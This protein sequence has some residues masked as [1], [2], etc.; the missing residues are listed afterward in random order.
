MIH[1]NK[2]VMKS[3]NQA[4]EEREALDISY[5]EMPCGAHLLDFGITVK[6]TWESALLFTRLTIGDLGTVTLGRWELDENYSFSCIDLFVSHPLIA[7]LGSQIAGWQLSDGE[8]ATIGSGP[9]RA[10]AAVASDPYLAMT[11]YRDTD[12]A[13][14]VLCIQDTRLPTDALALSVAQACGVTPEHVYIAIAP[15]ACIVGSVQVAARMLEQ[16]C[17]KMYEH[18]FAV[19]QIVHCR[20]RAPIA[21]VCN[22]EIIAMGRINDAILY[23]GEAEFWVDAADDALHTIADSLV[24]CSSS[25]E[26]GKSFGQ[27]FTESGKNFYHIDHE[28]HSIAVIQLHSVRTGLSVRVGEINREVLKKSFLTGIM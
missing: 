27:I 8:F 20:G 17:H 16:C 18:G 13:D 24:S 10:V 12:A 9:A 21:P 22:D 14:V 23:G 3:I 15:S 26:Y 11:P 19:S 2:R 5:A 1:I 28:V 4:V 6:G 25:P 7:C